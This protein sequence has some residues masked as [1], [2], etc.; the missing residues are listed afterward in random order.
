[1]KKPANNRQTILFVVVAI[2][3]VYYIIDSGMFSNGNGITPVKNLARSLSG[4]ENIPDLNDINRIIELASVTEVNWDNGWDKDPFFYVSPETL[5]SNDGFIEGILGNKGTNVEGLTLTGISWH[6]N[7]GY[8]IINGQIAKVDD[9]VKG[10]T[11][12]KITINEVILKQGPKTI[13][14]SLNGN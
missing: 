5:Q 12:K 9:V 7:S 10:H 3:V 2:L 6:G 4:N 8:A 13:K 11:V 1:M 14:L